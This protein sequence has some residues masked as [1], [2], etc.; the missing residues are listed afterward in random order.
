MKRFILSVLFLSVGAVAFGQKED[1]LK[2][3]DNCFAGGDYRCA[4]GNYQSYLRQ[5]P[6]SP[7]QKTVEEKKMKA[8]S[9][10]IWQMHA[11]ASLTKKDY[12]DAKANCEKILKLNPGDTYVQKQLTLCDQNLSGPDCLKQGEN[13]YNRGDYEEA[14]KWYRKG[15][16]QGYAKAQSNLGYMYYEGYGVTRD[17]REAIK[18]YR[19]SAEQGNADAQYNLGE[20]Y[21]NGKGVPANR[22]KAI[23]W[24]RKAA[25]QGNETAKENLKKLGV[26]Y[27]ESPSTQQTNHQ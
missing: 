7:N 11:E 25:G 4:S 18:W 10:I 23:E 21:Q 3:G 26:V 1:P 12:P 14:V 17:Y 20:M 9:C 24:Y 6:N 16:E 5:H 19:K 8:D 15:A 22:E 27:D 2:K 13:C